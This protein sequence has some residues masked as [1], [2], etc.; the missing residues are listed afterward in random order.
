MKI[1]P[2]N[3]KPII[4]AFKNKGNKS[5]EEIIDSFSNGRSFLP[6]NF[7]DDKGETWNITGKNEGKL[8]IWKEIK[9]TFDIN[10]PNDEDIY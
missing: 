5:Y 4:K 6:I 7:T 1:A 3:V 8:F 9:M 10:I 2:P